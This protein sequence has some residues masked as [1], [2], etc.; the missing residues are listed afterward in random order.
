MSNIIIPNSVTSIGDS[1]FSYCIG[2]SSISLPDNLET[3]GSSAFYKCVRLRSITLPQNITFI[4]ASAFKECYRITNATIGNGQFNLEADV[5]SGCTAIRQVTILDSADAISSDLLLSLTAN[6]TDS[7]DVSFIGPNCFHYLGEDFPLD[8]YIL[9]EG[10][11]YVDEIGVFYQ[12]NSD[13]TA[14]LVYSPCELKAEEYTILSSISTDDGSESYTVTTIADA[15]FKDHT[16]LKEVIIPDSITTIGNFAFQNCSGLTKVTIPESTNA[17]GD[18]AF[19]NCQGITQLVIPESITTLGSFAFQNCIQLSN[20]NGISSLPSVLTEWANAGAN[21]TTFHNTALSGEDNS[22][23]TEDIIFYE[24]PSNPETPGRLIRLSTE[25]FQ[26]LTGEKVNTTLTIQLGENDSTSVVRVYFR[27]TDKYGSVGFPL[28]DTLFDNTISASVCKADAPNTYFI[29]IDPLRAGQT[30]DLVMTPTYEKIVSGGG[31]A[32]IWVSALS[33]D[34]AAELGNGLT[35][36]K[37]SHMVIWQTQPNTFELTKNRT[38]SSATLMGNG[39]A[40]SD[41]LLKNLQYEIEIKRV[42]DSLDYGQDHSV[43]VDF[44]DILSLPANV[45]WREG[46]VQA[47]S[48]SNWYIKTERLSLHNYVTPIYYNCYHCYVKVDETEYLFATISVIDSFHLDNVG[49]DVDD[50]GNIQTLWTYFSPNVL[51]EIPAQKFYVT[52][53][54]E[55]ILAN[56]E[57]LAAAVNQANSPITIPFK[58][59]VD[60]IQHFSYSANQYL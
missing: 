48:D 33:V 28:G 58:N 18:C 52:F 41:P 21:S 17:V 5:F 32:L 59:T 56:A 9:A 35:V 6:A 49:L 22:I 51:E 45:Y 46:L 34:K 19:Y 26:V 15:V 37:N 29:E 24:K 20:V 39:T 53:G 44:V 25:K 57:N 7:I 50:E 14:A 1:A 11:Y 43:S 42:G 55:V 10:D 31:S 60:A 2:L 38:Y 30:L 8:K 27:F 12:I 13:G 47:I 4:G 23:T 40:Q 3:L 36:P 16:S 54:D